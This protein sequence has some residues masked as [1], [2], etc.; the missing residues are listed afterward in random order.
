MLATRRPTTSFALILPFRTLGCSKINSN[1][2]DN[3]SCK[4]S[5]SSEVLIF[6]VIKGASPW[7]RASPLKGDNE[8][9]DDLSYTE[10]SGSFSDSWKMSLPVSNGFPPIWSA[11]RM[12]PFSSLILQ[13][14]KMSLEFSPRRS[15][16]PPSASLIF[17]SK[18]EMY[19]CFRSLQAR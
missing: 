10:G 11:S 13:S 3:K 6:C 14:S 8:S 9:E 12:L 4:L 15:P 16:T 1:I 17:C 18:F 5:A 7:P 19:C 2:A